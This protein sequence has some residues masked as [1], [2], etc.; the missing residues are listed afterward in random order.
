MITKETLIIEKVAHIMKN[1]GIEE[2]TIH[3]LVTELGIN[4]NQLYHQF[5]N[6]NDILLM[7]LTA[8]ENELK[9]FAHEHIKNIEPPETE[10]KL[11]FKKLYFLFLQKPYYL[12]IIFDQRLIEKNNDIKKSF[13]RIR[14]IAATYLAE[15]INKGKNENVF[16]TNEST[17]T[18]VRKILNGFRAYMQDEHILNEMIVK[19][20]ALRTV[21]G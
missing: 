20:E 17:K 13:F 19:M 21:E 12:S 11:L 15:I 4:E 1:K 16:K 10:F 9:E 8:F 18:L 3:N 2:F 5:T 14:N 7:I 6:D